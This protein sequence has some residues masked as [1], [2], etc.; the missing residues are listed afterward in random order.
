MRRRLL[1]AA[2]AASLALGGAGLACDRE[3]VQ[4]VEEGVENVEKGVEEVGEEVEKQV[5]KADTDGKDD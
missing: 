5:D 1:A 4:D 2:T 3:D